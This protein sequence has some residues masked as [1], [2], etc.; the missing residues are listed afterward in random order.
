MAGVE[1]DVFPFE[2]EALHDGHR[3]SAAAGTDPALGI[4]DAMPGKAAPVVERTQRVADGACP[5][6]QTR[7]R[8]DLTIGRDPTARNAGN[9]RVDPLVTGGRRRHREKR[10]AD[11][12]LPSAMLADHSERC[13]IAFVR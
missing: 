8:R 2:T 10:T 12:R 5:A 9:D 4:D 3:A 1:P 6:R 11:R 7:E 13:R